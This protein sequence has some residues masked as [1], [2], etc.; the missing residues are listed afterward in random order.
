MWYASF[1]ANRRFGILE[2]SVTHLNMQLKVRVR[3]YISFNSQCSWLIICISLP[4][5]G[6]EAVENCHT[7][8]QLFLCKRMFL[9]FKV[10]LFLVITFLRIFFQLSKSSFTLGW[11]HIS[12]YQTFIISL[13]WEEL[14]AIRQILEIL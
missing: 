7:F 1:D 4:P 13:F 8:L 6:K 5:I 10:F 14:R 9:K 2:F 11:Y 12:Y 3:T